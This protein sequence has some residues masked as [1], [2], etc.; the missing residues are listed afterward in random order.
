MD[1]NDDWLIDSGVDQLNLTIERPDIESGNISETL[2]MLQSLLAS[3]ARVTRFANRVCLFIDGY[4][5]YPRE[6]YEVPEVRSFLQNL[7]SHFPY[8]LWF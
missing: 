2:S 1:T 4:N 6:L 8:W 5:D 7:D 3:E